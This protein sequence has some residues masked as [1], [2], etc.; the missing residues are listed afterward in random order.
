MYEL[1]FFFTFLY[2]L[3]SR[4]LTM[5]EQ[6]KANYKTY[7]A[8]INLSFAAADKKYVFSIEESELLSEFVGTCINLN[9]SVA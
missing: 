5:C 1:N 8:L 6:K 7:H 9:T 4:C 2:L 3:V